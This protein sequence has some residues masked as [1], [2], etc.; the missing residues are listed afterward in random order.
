MARTRSPRHGSMQFWP[1]VRA[2]RQLGSVRSWSK[3]SKDPISG[4]IGYK[5]GMTHVLGIETRKTATAKGEEVSYPVTIIECP[6]MKIAG[7]RLYKKKYMHNQPYK[8]ILFKLD[9]SLS[10]KI[11]LP[12]K[13][14]DIKLIDDAKESAKDLTDV[15]LLVYTQPSQ[16]GVSKKKPELMEVGLSGSIDEKIKFAKDNHDK[17]LLVNNI[18]KEGEFIDI[19]AVTKGK[20][21]QGSI[22][23][24]GVALKV[25][26]TEKGVRRVGTLGAWSGQGHVLYR[27]PHPGQMGYHLRTEYNKQI[28]KISNKPEEINPKGAFLQ[29]G[30][31]KSTY[32]LIKGS[33]SGARKRAVVF[34][35][36]MRKHAPST[37]PT[38]TYISTESKQ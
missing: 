8:D 26:K 5:V 7:V 34:A 20:G 36:A 4:F 33:V 25:H 37:L 1:R 24:F 27:V 2:K 29:Y 14:H 3:S 13:V 28:F 30:N 32:V 15:K 38:I 9:K 18:F 10:R 17:E 12:K 35:K 23:R 21:Y 11:V 31:V 22:K 6:P 16:A 19:H